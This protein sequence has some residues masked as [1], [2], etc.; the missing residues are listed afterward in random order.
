VNDLNE[1][2]EF[3]LR[4]ALDNFADQGVPVDESLRGSGASPADQQ[5]VRERIEQMSAGVRR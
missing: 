3:L 4:R 2:Q 5:V 1:E